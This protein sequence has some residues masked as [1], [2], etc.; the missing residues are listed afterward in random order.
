M[1]INEEQIS[2]AIFGS[3]I[4][5]K[6]LQFLFSNQSPLSER[7]L[8]KVIGTSHVSVNK[9]MK[10][11][12][13][14][15]VVKSTRVS[16]SIVWQLDTNS[17]AHRYIGL[18]IG[19][20]D[21]TPLDYIKRKVRDAVNIINAVLEF[22]ERE[23]QQKK[24]GGRLPR[25]KEAYI[26]GS[27]ADR[28]AGPKSDIDIL[29]VVEPKVDR[30]EFSAMLAST[31]GMEIYEKIGSEMSFHIYDKTAVMK[32]KPLWLRRAVRE[33]IKVY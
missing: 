18:V 33:G 13:A 26:F 23:N 25:I 7:E 14:V 19:G 12:E 30:S 5:R 31:V 8:A 4:K 1:H 6:V 10:Q 24:A 29:L 21:R 27:V 22:S 32:N 16:N 3:K 9:V 17:F 20:I 15:N 2:N 28:T 11:L